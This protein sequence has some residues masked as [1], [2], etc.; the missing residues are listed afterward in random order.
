M[1]FDP[2]SV[3]THL[4]ALEPESRVSP[5]FR[6]FRTTTN[7]LAEWMAQQKV[8]TLDLPLKGSNPKKSKVHEPRTWKSPHPKKEEPD[9]KKPEKNRPSPSR[10]VSPDPYSK[11][12]ACFFRG[13]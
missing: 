13:L 8:Q 9:L 12:P 3:Q 7:S 5:K 1:N 6:F 10:P 2:G 11:Y 4:S